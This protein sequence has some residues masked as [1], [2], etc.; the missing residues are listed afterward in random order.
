MSHCTKLIILIISVILL[1]NISWADESRYWQCT[2]SDDDNKQWILNSIYERRA[3]AK[4][5]DAC[6]K[7]SLCPVSCKTDCEG[8]NHGKS[9]RP[10]WQCTALDQ[11]AKSWVSSPC[12]LSDDAAISAKMRCKKLSSVP[13]TCYLNMATCKNLNQ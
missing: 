3:R 2:T 12:P 1:T 9:I 5:S 10:I 11:N 4:T 13:D 8:F 6:K 7:Q